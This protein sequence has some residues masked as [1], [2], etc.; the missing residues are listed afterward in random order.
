[1]LWYS[2]LRKPENPSLSAIFFLRPTSKYYAY[3]DFCDKAFCASLKISHSLQ[4]FA[5]IILMCVIARSL[6]DVAI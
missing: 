3:S 1:M 6:S 4:F 5:T 2:S